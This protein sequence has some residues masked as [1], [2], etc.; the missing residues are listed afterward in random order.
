[1][2]KFYNTLTNTRGDSLPNYRVQVTNSA[3][4]VQ[5][6]Y[7]DSGGTRFTDGDGNNVNYATA[8]N[9]GFVEFY[10][11]PAAGQVLQTLDT[12][13]DLVKA[14]AD[15][16]DQYVLASLTGPIAQ[17]AVTDLVSDLA[18]KAATADLADESTVGK[19][20]EL[21]ARSG[22]A[23][24]T[25]ALMDDLNT[26]DHPYCYLTEAGREGTFKWDSSDLSTEVAADT[27]QGIYVPPSSDATG[28]SGAWVRQYEG[29]VNIKW[30][31][32]VADW[33]GTTGTDNTTAI[34][35]AVSAINALGG[36]VVRV[37]EG[38]FRTT[39]NIKL[40]DGVYIIGEGY[41]SHIHNNQS[42]GFQKC[43]I[44]SGNMG[45]P[46]NGN[47][48]FD[49]A[50]YDT[51]AVAPGD[52][53]VTLTV[54]ANAA[55]FSVGE[56]VGLESYETW[57]LAA[58]NNHGKWLNQNVVTAVDSGTGVITLRYAIPDTYTSAGAGQRP[59]LKR[60]S[61]TINGYDGA[62]LW[63]SKDCG[64]RDLR[65][66]QSIGG[67]SGW[68]CL[69]PCGS[70][71]H[72]EN[73]WMDNCSTLIGSNNLDHSTFRN[74]Q[75]GFEA[76]LFDFSEWQNDI[77][78]ENVIAHRV[79][80]NANLNRIGGAV[81]KGADF[82]IRNLKAYL[83]GWGRGASMFIVHRGRIQDCLIVE[84]G[85]ASDTNATEAILLG[86]GDD[87]EASGNIIIDQHKYGIQVLS[88]RGKAFNNQIP[89]TNSSYVSVY[90][91]ATLTSAHI[92]G[93]VFG[94]EGSLTS[95][96]RFQQQT[97]L[98][99]GVR[100]EGNSGYVEVQARKGRV[101]WAGFAST[102]NTGSFAVIKTA[103]V[104]GTT[105]IVRGFRIFAAGT[106]GGTASTKEVRLRLGSNTIGQVSYAAPDTNDWAIEAVLNV[107]TSSDAVHCSYKARQG[108][109]L[110]Q[111][112]FTILAGA[113]TAD[114]TITV[115]GQ[116][117]NAADSVVC[118]MFIVEPIIEQRS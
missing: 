67:T 34:N 29:G 6:I 72:Y 43:V 49:E 15:F 28:A 62:A 47:S 26:T 58:P 78:V 45:D 89:K 25:R 37:P 11:T 22:P 99:D 31:G 48:L 82:T 73:I 55:N 23:V 9:N 106:R 54:P 38:A 16:A 95:R 76:G 79:A 40:L 65:L 46:T 70:N 101:N 111:T 71:Q 93:N 35:G 8:D 32:A 87:C 52:F 85:S 5:T 2:I 7:A 4:T 19:G 74:I 53:Q 39:G 56:I 86:Y 94:I 103:N 108:T 10:W 107:R 97:A 51:F 115:E 113:L 12:S 44:A 81:N 57:S 63:M 98:A 60:L 50:G 18:A 42:N 64:A 30:F 14:V 80:A 41:E 21:V 104:K 84:S 96:D 1:M 59:K 109:G 105:G 83:D 90:A 69:F 13:G 116:V 24:A 102:S 117:A 118:Y 110:D 20:A 17:S 77:L 100:V 112:G 75:G 114:T 36:G 66:T 92:Y 3:G 91:P 33:D 88:P 27:Q 68:Y 61:G